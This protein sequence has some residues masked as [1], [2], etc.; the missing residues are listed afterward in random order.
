MTIGQVAKSAG[1]G[2]ETV[3]F[4][5]RK[6]LLGKP[7]RRASGYREYAEDAVHR[8]QFVQRSQQLGFS[9]REIK[10]LLHL[11]VS[12]GAS[13]ADVRERAQAKLADIDAKLSEL[14]SMKTAL[15]KVAAKCTGRGPT[16][17]CPVLDALQAEGKKT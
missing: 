16:S 7:P 14:R 1:V 15:E 13:C 11:R 9:L 4:Y 6:G 17:Q 5:E 12:P 10:D 3:R 2:V 8:I